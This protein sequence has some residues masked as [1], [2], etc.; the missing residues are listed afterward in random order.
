MR[1]NIKKSKK[2]GRGKDSRRKL[3]R[4]LA[5]SVI[6]YEKIQT[7]QANAKAIRSYVDKM[8]T[9]GKIK[10]LHGN[11]QLFA[12]L[13]KNAALKVIEVLTERYQS[14]K[15]GYTRILIAGKSKDGMNKYLVELV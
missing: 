15:G 7:S 4:T 6:V 11:R 9:K 13:S 10:T 2:I 5:S 14:R 8:I 12:D 1:H 3:L